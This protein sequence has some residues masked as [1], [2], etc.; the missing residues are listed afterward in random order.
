MEKIFQ[1]KSFE[2]INEEYIV[3]K[4]QL[5]NLQNRSKK[6]ESKIID[7]NLQLKKE[8]LYYDSLPEG[9]AR[10]K[11]SPTFQKKLKLLKSQNNIKNSLERVKKKMLKYENYLNNREKYNNNIFI[12]NDSER[13]LISK[14]VR[15]AKKTGKKENYLR[16][17]KNLD[18]NI[19]LAKETYIKN[20]KSM[21]DDQQINPETL[22]NQKKY[23]NLQQKKK[24]LLN[25]IKKIQES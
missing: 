10:I 13:N 16:S 22:S 17:L 18:E 20:L 4:V 19:D 2:I 9:S 24:I 8:V 12:G 23:F 5:R 1:N 3:L 14:K 6:N 7:N 15:F 25:K 21:D 11:N